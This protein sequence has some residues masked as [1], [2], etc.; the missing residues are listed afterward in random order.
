MKRNHVWFLLAGLAACEQASVLDRPTVVKRVLTSPNLDILFVIDNSNS[1][2]DKQSL[3]A[4]NFASL[5]AS[6][7]AFPSGRPNLHI[8][9]VST[10]VGTGSDADFGPSCPKV[11]PNDDGLLQNTP[12]I[13]GCMGPTGRFL[14]DIRSTGGHTT[15]YPGTLPEAFSCIATLGTGGCGFEAPLEAMKRALDGSRPENAGFLRDDADLA[16]II[17]TDEDDCSVA[18]PA[19]F[20]LDLAHVGTGDFRC[21]PLFAYDCDSPISGTAPGTYT[22][23]HTHHGGYLKDP[24][25]YVEFLHTIKDPSSVMVSVIAGDPSATIHTGSITNPFFQSLA[26]LPSCHVDLSDG[27][28]IGRPGIRLD[29]FR[30]QLG[31]QGGFQSV[32]QTDYSGALQQ[33]G[34]GMFE[35]MSPCLSAAV[36]PTDVDASNP[37]LQPDC[38][39]TEHQVG[40]QQAVL[41]PTC[42]INS[43]HMVDDDSPL[44]CWWVDTSPACLSN[45]LELHVERTTAPPVGSY[46]EASCVKL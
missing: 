16:V 29:D 10:T 24:S 31:E 27:L 25:S 35:M 20:A 34:V 17:L 11:A 3:F 36:D 28:A 46:V 26:L 45:R 41:I 7:D 2:A 1:T 9:V 18:D 43:Y 38:S 15:N 44:P 6:L 40:S 37:G 39:V 21:Q 4:A 22:N 13:P 8:G 33:I 23:C 42:K 30:Q 12:R 32:C 5:A 14:D 19:L